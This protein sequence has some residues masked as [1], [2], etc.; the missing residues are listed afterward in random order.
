MLIINRKS[1]E[2]F[3][4]GENLEIKVSL[5][6]FSGNQVRIG[7]DAPHSFH[8][9]REELLPLNKNQTLMPFSKVKSRDKCQK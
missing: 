8:I 6:K 7:I 4:I 1:G 2:S 9:L 3:F 5:M